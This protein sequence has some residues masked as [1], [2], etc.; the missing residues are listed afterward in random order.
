MDVFDEI[1]KQDDHKVYPSERMNHLFDISG[2][3]IGRYLQKKL[4]ALDIWH[5]KYSEIKEN[6][7]NSIQICEKWVAVCETLTDK[8]WKTY[9]PHPWKE[10][11]YVPV[12]L[13]KLCSRIQ[14]VIF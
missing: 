2:G 5:G 3:S 6:L 7:H 10:D 13:I 4:S 1:W 14:E 8:F 12:N 11:K 9:H